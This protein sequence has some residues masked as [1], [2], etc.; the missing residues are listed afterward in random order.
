MNP[1]QNIKYTLICE[2]CQELAKFI[3]TSCLNYFTCQTHKTTHCSLPQQSLPETLKPS[4][5]LLK[6]D[7]CTL[8]TTINTQFLT[9]Q[10]TFSQIQEQL[11][12]LF[13]K[14][15]S[16][17]TN[18]L[19]ELELSIGS[20]GVNNLIFVRSKAL[21]HSLY[22]EDIKGLY[23]GDTEWFIRKIEDINAVLMSE[24]KMGLG[25][26]ELPENY[27]E[28]WQKT[29]ES[30][31]INDL[32]AFNDLVLELEDDLAKV[33]RKK[34]EVNSALL[35]NSEFF[36][37]L[38]LVCPNIYWVQGKLTMSALKTLTEILPSYQKLTVL[39]LDITSQGNNQATDL[40]QAISKLPNLSNLTLNSFNL[41]FLNNKPL[42]IAFPSLT[43]CKI[44][45]NGPGNSDLCIFFKVLVQSPELRY[46]TIRNNTLTESNI[47][48]LTE[49]VDQMPQLTYLSISECKLDDKIEQ[50]VRKLKDNNRVSEFHLKMNQAS[51][52]TLKRTYSLL[53]WSRLDRLVLS[54]GIDLDSQST[55]KASQARVFLQN[56]Q[57][58]LKLI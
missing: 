52:N 45:N 50:L 19:Q 33:L 4:K 34:I 40:L 5:N 37:G 54:F 58:I 22:S 27:R 57:L 11:N 16:N 51:Y 42:R 29:K 56:K 48:I 36:K 3:C 35:R 2:H 6:S 18:A 24:R 38:P 41:S 15:F 1:I 30:I 21:V 12:T 47:I 13:N 25:L 39:E 9:F 31:L 8:Y 7:L 44:S 28:M 43:I 53:N 17:F 10:Q 49:V 32:D 14:A 26:E 23:V 55:L 20:F 46:L